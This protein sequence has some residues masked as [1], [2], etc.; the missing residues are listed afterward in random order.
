MSYHSNLTLFLVRAKTSDTKFIVTLDGVE[1]DDYDVRNLLLV[2]EEAPVAD[3]DAT[4]EESKQP[5][6]APPKIKPFSISLKDSDGEY[7]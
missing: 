7:W 6:K 1:F 2:E 5:K 3:R 4:K